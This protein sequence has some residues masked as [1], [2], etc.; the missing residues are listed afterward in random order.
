MEIGKLINEVR[1]GRVEFRVDKTAVVHAPIGKA[2]FTEEQ[3][4]ENL[5]AFMDAIVRA[6]PSAAKGVY[7]R[8]IALAPTMGPSVKMDVPPTLALVSG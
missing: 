4:R 2:S 1:A 8:S 5:V 6:K 7:I 3:L